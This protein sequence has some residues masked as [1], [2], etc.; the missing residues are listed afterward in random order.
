VAPAELPPGEFN[1]IEDAMVLQVRQLHCSSAH[2]L[3]CQ[4]RLQLCLS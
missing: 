4:L 1:C 3:V 2:S